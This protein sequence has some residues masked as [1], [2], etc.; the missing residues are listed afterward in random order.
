MTTEVKGY[1]GNAPK[2]YKGERK[3]LTPF[4]QHVDMFFL[5]NPSK[6]PDELTKVLFTSSYL[7]GDAETWFRPYLRDYT[8]NKPA[9]R[10]TDTGAIFGTYKGFKE[11]LKTAFGVQNEERE[12]E[13]QV[14]N[15]RQTGSAQEYATKFRGLVAILEWDDSVTVPIFRE[16]LKPA[17]RWELRN[18][19]TRRLADLMAEA[20][21]ID[22]DLWDFHKG[23]QRGSKAVYVAKGTHK[24]NTPKQREPYYGPMPMDLDAAQKKK[25]NAKGKSQ[26]GNKGAKIPKEERERRFKEKLCLYCGKPGHVARNCQSKAQMHNGEKHQRTKEMNMAEGEAVQGKGTVLDGGLA[27]V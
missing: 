26:R 10:S 5:M 27:E 14:M 17:I 16:G 25:G 23:R 11:R 22:S 7:E 1:L 12:A 19:T 20:I 24:P 15:L 3:G 18:N 13:G 4:L 8:T 2:P 6:F 9:D 21:K